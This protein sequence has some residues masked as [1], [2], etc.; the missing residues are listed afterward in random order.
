MPAPKAAFLSA[1]YRLGHQLPLIVAGIYRRRIRQMEERGKG[2]LLLGKDFC[3]KR[4]AASIHSFVS[5]QTRTSQVKRTI[6]GRPAITIRL[7]TS[8]WSL[9]TADTS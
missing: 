2:F 1:D 4:T 7:R 9:A 6:P 5:P 8:R 3:K